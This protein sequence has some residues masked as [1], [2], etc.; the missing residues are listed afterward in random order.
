MNK[1]IL[2]LDTLIGISIISVSLVTAT[3][4]IHNALA[5]SKDLELLS[6]HYFLACSDIAY[7]RS[8]TQ[9]TLGEVKPVDGFL[10][11]SVTVGTVT[12]ESVK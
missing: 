6:E 2:L 12:F 3:G 1:G 4:F 9:T 10:Y 5:L 8:N 11:Y 7:F